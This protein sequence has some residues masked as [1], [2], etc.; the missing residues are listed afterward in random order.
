M[1][2]LA[3]VLVALVMLQG[4]ASRDEAYQGYLKAQGE[5]QAAYYRAAAQPLVDITL[6]APEGQEY[7]MVVNRE[8]KP[9]V[10]EQQKDNEWTKPVT[11]AVNG[12]TVY[13]GIKAGGE[14]VSAIAS[15]AGTRIEGDGNQYQSSGDGDP[16]I[17][18]NSEIAPEPEENAEEIDMP[19][20]EA[21]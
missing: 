8:I 4:C 14:F 1:I 16:V 20:E 10:T 7:H 11:A 12:L 17:G 13:G 6:P 19:V 3:L 21:E 9:M 15:G 2:K 18:G 5:A